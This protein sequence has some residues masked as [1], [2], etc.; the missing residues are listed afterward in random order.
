[1]GTLRD[2][3]RR[4]SGIQSTQKITRAMKMVASAKLRRA[5]ESIINAR[6]YAK[7]ISL[8][9]QDLILDDDSNS[10]FFLKER[11][12]KKVLVVVVTSDK[13]LCGSFNTNLI[14]ESARVINE[15]KEKS[16]FPVLYCIGK[17]G[18]DYFSKRGYE[19]FNY[20]VGVFAGL[21]NETALRVVS[22]II[23]GYTEE[24]YDQVEVIYNE[25]KSVIQQKIVQEQYLPI[26][27]NKVRDRKETAENFIY[28]MNREE[29]LNYILPKHL[30]SQIWRV[31]LESNA[32]ELGAKMT[33]MENATTN[34]Q[35]LIRTLKIKYNKERQAAITKELIEVV[36]GANALRS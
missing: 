19:I 14:K 15:Y 24:K 33:A 6:P 17:K 30:N 22:E 21:R 10:S 20:K 18:Y 36:S 28:E 8:F 7:R 27:V 34:A 12:V 11:E 31:L 13:G 4:I 26:P 29:I 9:L 1:M 2:T 16:I 3:K 32:A 25:F 23:K 5:Q 35:E